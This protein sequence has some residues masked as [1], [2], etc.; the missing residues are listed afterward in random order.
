MLIIADKAKINVCAASCEV[1]HI[2]SLST[3]QRRFHELKRPLNDLI[4]ARYIVQY[5]ECMTSSWMGHKI[6]GRVFCACFFDEQVDGG[7]Q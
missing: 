4:R 1:E 7:I 3:G 5:I 6:E 2:L